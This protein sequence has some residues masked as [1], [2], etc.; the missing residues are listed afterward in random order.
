MFELKR[1]KKYSV[2]DFVTIVLFECG[3]RGLDYETGAEYCS[4][5]D[6]G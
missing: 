4:S 3:S 6:S 5:Q 1:R 2:R